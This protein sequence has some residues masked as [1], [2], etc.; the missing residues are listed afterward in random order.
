MPGRKFPERRSGLRPSEKE[1]HAFECIQICVAGFLG[2]PAS[3]RRNLEAGIRDRNSGT[4]THSVALMA[5]NAPTK[6]ATLETSFRPFHF[7][8]HLFCATDRGLHCPFKL[9]FLL[10]HFLSFVMHS[11][12]AERKYL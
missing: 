6:N 2:A 11:V 12:F 5:G 8:V 10:G 9:S 4:T 1:R 7:S 3:N